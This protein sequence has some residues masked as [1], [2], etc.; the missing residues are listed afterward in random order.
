MLLTI[1]IGNTNMEFGVYENDVLSVNFRLVTK[2]D[3]TSDEIGLMASQFFAIHGIE[4][5]TFEDVVITSVVPQVMHSV[6]NAIRKYIGREPLTVGENLLIDIQNKYDNPKEV[7]ADR[8][9][10]A[11]AGFRKYGGPLIV[12]DFGTATTFDVISDEGAY[13]G[14]VIYPGIR[15]SMDA[16]FQHAAKL[17]RVEIARPK[18]AIGR[19]TVDSMQAGAIYGYVGAVQNIVSAIE[20]ELG[21]KTRVIATG[22]LA[23]LIGKQADL[24]EAIDR[25]LT[26]D[27]LTM[28]Y[29]DY[30]NRLSD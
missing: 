2:Q 24:F 19:N 9:V 28:I 20:R 30:R 25:S 22:G 1:D 21:Q 7:G 26:L 8:L 15:I 23:R 18:H 27:G 17:P 16:L 6:N 5:S 13:L 4:P 12:V 29:R 10:N 3:I 14:G 11:Y